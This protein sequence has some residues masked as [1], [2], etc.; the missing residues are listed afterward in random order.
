WFVDNKPKFI[1][2]LKEMADR[3]QIEIIGGGYYE[4]IYAII[5]YRDKIAQMKKLSLLI[6][7][8]FDLQ[9]NGAWLAERVWEPNYPSFL[10]EIG[11]KYVILDDNHFRSTGISEDETL[12]SYNTED[13]GKS[14]RIFPINEELRYLTPWKP[15]T[16][17]IEYL[18]KIADETGDRMALLISDAEK[19]GVWGSTHQ[20]C[21]NEGYGHDEGDSGKP[22]IPTLFRR[23]IENNWIK[24]ITLSEY[25][26]KYP[27]KDLVY[28]PAASYDKM[29]EWVLPTKIRRKFEN[30]RDKLRDSDE[31]QDLYMFLKG[32]FWR[33][34]LVKYPE[35]NNMHKKMLYI[36]EKILRIESKLDTL[37][38]ETKKHMIQEKIEN[39]WEE[40]Y[41][42]QCNDAYWHGLFGGVYLQFLRFAIY[43]NLI[44][45]ENL[46]DEITQYLYPKLDSYI[47]ILPVDFY[48]KSRSEL[49][50]E[51]DLLN[52]YT[53]PAEGGTIFELDYKPKSYNLLNTLTRWEEA[54]HKKEKIETNEISV[55]RYRRSMLRFRVFQKKVSLHELAADTYKECSNFLDSNFEVKKSEKDGEIAIIILEKLAEIKHPTSKKT[56]LMD[57][58]KK[59]EVEKNVI[60]L[61]IMGKLKNS[62]ETE[63]NSA[64]FLE[65]FNFGIDLPFFFNGDPEKFTWKSSELDEHLIKDNRLQD[66]FEYLGSNFSA[67]DETYDLTFE[68]NIDSDLRHKIAKFPLIS[69]TWT[70]EGYKHIYQGI[71][72]IPIFNFENDFIIK[73]R[74]TI[75]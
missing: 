44:N 37:D 22:F 31:K 28:L 59:I 74:L 43:K 11:L 26:E 45:A 50:L 65:S 69:Y 71:N 10:S 1:Q 38:D 8:E 54:Y 68:V 12:Y 20:I 73:I 4:P 21:Y 49:I 13:E 35:S 19:M 17:T 51:S 25:M 7:K 18:K 33:Y 5:P 6:E 23:I 46:I 41:K 40:I 9:V 58:Q 63:N 3:K 66:K 60:T 27:A 75:T 39:A 47:S 52:L 32:G 14:L 70:D 72:L 34:F 16:Q 57:L 53:D 62:N 29:E 36:R 67:Y 55:D 42:S 48:K 24:S 64:E 30:Y 2:K 15:T 56:N 61:S